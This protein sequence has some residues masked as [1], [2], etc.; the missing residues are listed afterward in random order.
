[1]TWPHCRRR[2]IDFI[3]AKGLDK[4]GP[5]DLETWLGGHR[6][7]MGL[8]FEWVN[9]E[10]WTWDAAGP[11]WAPTEPAP[12]NDLCLEIYEGV[13]FNAETCAGPDDYLCERAPAGAA[14]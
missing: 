6:V 3:V 10:P 5:M 11:P 9:G 12:D 2:E 7:P 14:P 8:A 4:Y 1:V 13:I